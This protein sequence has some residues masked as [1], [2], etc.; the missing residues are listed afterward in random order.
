MG[1]FSF[2][3][4]GGDS[5]FGSNP[6]S[7][8]SPSPAS[9]SGGSSSTNDWLGTLFKFAQL[10]TQTYLAQDALNSPRVGTIVFGPNG[11]PIQVGSGTPA[12]GVN[13]ILGTSSI[14]LFL[15]VAVLL[16]LLLKK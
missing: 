10:G 8:A 14:W 3:F 7:I 2:G 13:S 11:Q 1:A 4:G 16:L 5:F 15:F 9:S 6:A 12:G